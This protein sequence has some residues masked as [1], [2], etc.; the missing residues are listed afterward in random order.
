MAT[1]A[2]HHNMLPNCPNAGAPDITAGM[3]LSGSV[4]I[5][6]GG[7]TGAGLSTST[8]LAEANGTVIIAT[9]R[10]ER[11]EA[12]SRQLS[13]RTGAR[14]VA[15]YLDLASFSSIRQFSAASAAALAGRSLNALV[16]SAAALNFGHAR[17][18][19]EDGFTRTLAVNFL[20]HAYLTMLL[21]PHLRAA[22]G[23]VVY[24]ASGAVFNPCTQ[25]GDSQDNLPTCMPTTRLAQEYATPRRIDTV[26]DGY[27]GGYN[28]SDVERA[29]EEADAPPPMIIDGRYGLSKY[30]LFLWAKELARRE[31]TL[32]SYSVHPGY[33][34]SKMGVDPDQTGDP[35]LEAIAIDPTAR[36]SID[37][38]ERRRR[39][40]NGIYLYIL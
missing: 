39:S 31:P 22:R 18:L 15:F 35:M 24:V 19:T 17:P 34:G 7:D 16:C 6:T 36:D 11:G 13:R 23:T 4:F 29:Q 2:H 8:A 9:H 37:I 25:L 33:F 20:G 27:T 12:I 21:L 40:T 30:L 5:V 14:V 10:L 38:G 26:A 28:Q 32:Y 1:S 3:T